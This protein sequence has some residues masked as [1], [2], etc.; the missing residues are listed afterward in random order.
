[1]PSPWNS[2]DVQYSQNPW[3]GVTTNQRPDWYVPELYAAFERHTIFNQFVTQ[4]FN[5]N[6][7]RAQT[8]HLTTPINPQPDHSPVGNR[9]LYFDTAYMDSFERRVTFQSYG[10]KLSW[11]K[12]DAMM[13]YWNNGNL[14]GVIDNGLGFMVAHTLDKL[15][16]DAFIRAP[17]A[18]FKA[19]GSGSSFNDITTS[20]LM[21]VDVLKDIQ[22]GIG[23]RETPLSNITDPRYAELT[24]LISPGVLADLRA[25]GVSGPDKRDTF[26]SVKQYTGGAEIMNGEVGLLH[27][28][29]LIVS[30]LCTLFNSGTVIYQQAITSAVD[31]GDGAPD[32]A[33]TSVDTVEYVGQPGATH[34]IAVAATVSFNIG[35]YV[36]IHKTRTSA[37]GVTNGV[38]HRDGSVCHRKITGKTSNTL[39]F[40]R[41]ILQNFNVDLGG[42]VYGYV[43]K[44]R[45][46]HMSV[47]LNGTDGV[48]RAMAQAPTLYTNEPK[49]DRRM[50]WSVSWDAYL[51]YTPFNKEA[52]EVAFTAGSFRLQ[53]RKIVQ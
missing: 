17:Y 36:T 43:T 18:Y 39:T 46:I 44:A 25:E 3:E 33:T 13:T 26:V 34:S 37:F 49:D 32:P 27:G 19:N 53:G 14:S 38:D 42:G 51:G 7:P 30:P 10:G 4:E 16:R 29:R 23:Y 1:M 35:D 28:W 8:L 15:A 48:V 5:V 47:F 9:Q 52:F 22:L 41:P 24:A 45:H 40:D 11:S 20:D 50:Q 12:Y 21:T 2:F 31:A 6:G